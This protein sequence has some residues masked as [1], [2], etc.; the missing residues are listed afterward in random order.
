MSDGDTTMSVLKKGTNGKLHLKQIEDSLNRRFHDSQS[1][2]LVH[3][4]FQN[5]CTSNDH[6]RLVDER[7]MVGPAIAAGYRL[8]K[9]SSHSRS[10]LE[11]CSRA[12][13]QLADYW[14]GCQ[15]TAR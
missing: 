15:T 5:T 8:C 1:H 13:C 14:L 10:R 7:K 3:D 4:I 6:P 11:S 2:C 9:Q 12:A